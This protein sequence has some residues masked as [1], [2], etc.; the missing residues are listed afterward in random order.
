MAPM[1][2]ASTPNNPPLLAEDA[3]NDAEKKVLKAFRKGWEAGQRETVVHPEGIRTTM[4]PIGGGP[5]TEDWQG[6]ILR[7]G[8]LRNLLL[9]SY[10]KFTPRP[11]VISCARIEG[12]LDLDYY[13]ILF[14][15]RFFWCIFPKGIS[16]RAAVIPQLELAKCLIGQAGLYAPQVRVTTGVD[17]NNQFKSFGEVNLDGANIGGQLDCSDGHFEA[18]LKAQHMKTGEDVFL[19][20]NFESN[21]EVVLNGA[22]IGRQLDCS[23]GHF[24]KG[25]KAQNMKTG[26][27]VFLGNEFGSN[28]EVILSGANIGGQLVCADGYFEKGLEAQNLKAHS[29][30]FLSGGFSSKGKVALSGANIGGRLVCLSGSFENGLEALHLKTG[31]SVLLSGGFNSKGKVILNGADIGGQ[32]VCIG[33][34]FRGSLI[35]QNLKTNADVFLSENFESIGEVVLSGANI[36]GQLVCAGG[37]FEEGLIAQRIKTGE[38]VFLSDGFSSNGLVNLSEANVGGQLACAG[39]CFENGL[40]ADGLRYQKIELGGDWEEGLTWLRKMPES[41]FQPYEQ[42]MMVYR[43]MGHP[44]WAREIG[45]WLEKKRHEQSTGGLWGAWHSILNWT[46]GYGYK[47]F[48]SLWW[49]I[50]LPLVG[51]ILFSACT[52][53]LSSKFTSCG[54]APAFLANE[55][56]PSEGKALE[57]WGQKGQAPQDYPE[58]QPFIYSVEATFPVLPLGQLDKWHPDK[59]FFKWVRWILT[60]IGSVLL[61]ILVLFGK[62]VLAP[63]QKSEGDS[64]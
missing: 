57:H 27:D 28:G 2:E 44:N 32:L 5:T 4:E 49:A 46:I 33:S 54:C 15:L 52:Q 51:T 53:S 43:R 47:P 7:V 35:A 1:S 62:V 14:P 61:P 34:H 25:L 56:I 55:W 38:G 9:G 26:E 42:L 45:F 18:G 17:L 59:I 21:G 20:E 6:A 13:E 41:E 3:L 11:V 19:N 31:E 10:D 58:F 8:F 16:L 23:D 63:N 36:G 48:R 22:N 64:S 40:T 30:V 50:G 37:Y 39:G 24:K 12:A 29:D 60:I